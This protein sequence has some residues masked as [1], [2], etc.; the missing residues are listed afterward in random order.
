M[1]PDK[2]LS[3]QLKMLE[4]YINDEVENKKSAI[5]TLSGFPIH[6]TSPPSFSYLAASVPNK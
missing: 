2:F 1:L 6:F 4:G 3:Y 5:I